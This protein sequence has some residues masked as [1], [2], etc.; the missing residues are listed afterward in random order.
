MRNSGQDAR[1]KSHPFTLSYRI[2]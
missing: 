1:V 2:W